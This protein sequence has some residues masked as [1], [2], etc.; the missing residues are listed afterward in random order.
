[1]PLK[2]IETPIGAKG[3]IPAKYLLTFT[4]T[5][6]P[7]ELTKIRK[8]IQDSLEAHMAAQ[9][10]DPASPRFKMTFKWE[11]MRSYKLTAKPKRIKRPSSG[12]TDT[13][14]KPKNSILPM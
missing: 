12:G 13:Q 10:K 9:E 4:G 6:K 3:V 14:P 2:I 1:M 5:A 7:V 11:K 8:K